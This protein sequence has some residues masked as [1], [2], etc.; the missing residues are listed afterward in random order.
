MACRRHRCRC[1]AARERA[2][3][4]AI[5]RR[6]R[7]QRAANGS[8]Y[9]RRRAYARN[10]DITPRRARVARRWRADTRVAVLFHVAHARATQRE[11]E[12]RAA[13]ERRR[14]T[15][16]AT[17]ILPPQHRRAK[18]VKARTHSGASLSIPDL[19]CPS[20]RRRCPYAQSPVQ[21]RVAYR[22]KSIVLHG[23]FVR[24]DFHAARAWQAPQ[25]HRAIF[26]S[27]VPRTTSR[28]LPN[29]AAAR[30]SLRHGFAHAD[31][32]LCPHTPYYL[33]PRFQP[34]QRL[35]D[36]HVLMTARLRRWQSDTRCATT[37]A[38]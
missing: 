11:R 19:F 8:S 26:L 14:K 22:E 17:I 10:A 25:A 16:A 37:T 27:T 12:A 20:D 6:P 9:T 5:R 7:T 23:L 18:R 31:A 21:R 36:S 4:A 13:C 33:P 34:F 35:A 30:R 38:Y 1:A 32:I 29:H 28:P 3:S 2:R 24:K 15:C